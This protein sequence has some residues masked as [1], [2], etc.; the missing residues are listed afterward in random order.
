M[1]VPK[2]QEQKRIDGLDFSGSS[3]CVGKYADS[4]KR[5]T[6]FQPVDGG[7]EA[8]GCDYVTVSG[9]GNQML[10][11]QSGTAFGVNN[12][13]GMSRSSI[14]GGER[15]NVGNMQKC[16]VVANNSKNNGSMSCV[17]LGG[18]SNTVVGPVLD[19]IVFGQSLEL[20]NVVHCLAIGYHSGASGMDDPDA[21]IS[22]Y[23]DCSGFTRATFYDGL[24]ESL[25]RY[26]NLWI[27]GRIIADGG[28]EGGE[29]G[30]PG[31]Q[32]PPGPQGEQGP[33]G[34]QGETGEKG[35]KGDRGE[36]GE[37]G[38]KGEKGDS[39]TAI[40]N[41]VVISPNNA[42][43]LVHSFTEV[44]FTRGDRIGYAGP[45][46]QIVANSLILPFNAGV[47]P[48]GGYFYGAD[49]KFP[50]SNMPRYIYSSTNRAISR[51][52]YKITRSNVT[53]TA[54]NIIEVND[55][56]A[57]TSLGTITTYDLSKVSIGFK[58]NEI[59]PPGSVVGG[60]VFE[61]GYALC[62]PVSP[63]VNSSGETV[64]WASG[65]AYRWY[66]PFASIDEYNAAVGLT[67]ELLQLT[68]IVD[69]PTTKG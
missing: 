60:T 25:D 68:Q 58:W 65:S 4:K 52:Y 43:Y 40:E 27:K 54:G 30:D 42:A 39:G 55:S 48:S 51:I 6:I 23:Y 66:M 24:I 26:G 50:S 63:Y 49:I 44:L 33:P 56:G 14:V 13:A 36:K 62:I 1:I 2:T 28:I 38:E 11:C 47:S 59:Y 5:A 57:E 17:W 10:N 7:N 35:D 9:Q 53:S 8:K 20:S 16:L 18:E 34:P 19:S 69:N 31:P 64:M 45:E 41:A 67:S 29:K 46:N 12:V 3:D 22:F 61:Y 15:N 32:G 37:Q 21:P